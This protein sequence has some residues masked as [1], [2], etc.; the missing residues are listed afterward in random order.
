MAEKSKTIKTEMAERR[1]GDTH[2]LVAKNDKAIKE[3]GWTPKYDCIEKI[4]KTAWDWEQNRH[5]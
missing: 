1:F 2:E 4:V 3:L 5:Y